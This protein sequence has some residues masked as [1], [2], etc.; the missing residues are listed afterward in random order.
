M[1]KIN[2]VIIFSYL[3]KRFVLIWLSG[4][5]SADTLNVST[6]Q[7]EL[8]KNSEKLHPFKILPHIF[9]FQVPYLREGALFGNFYP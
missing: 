5:F 9:V 4:G 8:L 6:S 1:T 2:Y 7:W 3:I